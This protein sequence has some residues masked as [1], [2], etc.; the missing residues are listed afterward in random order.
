MKLP[1]ISDAIL[2]WSIWR[3]AIICAWLGLAAFFFLATFG[4]VA[5]AT[6]TTVSGLESDALGL[7]GAAVGLMGFVMTGSFSKLTSSV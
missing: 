3:L 7:V 2:A 1:A 5:V 4:G 6:S